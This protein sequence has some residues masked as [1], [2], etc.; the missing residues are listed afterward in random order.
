METDKVHPLKAYRVKHG[1]TLLQ[2]ADLV[3]VSEVS[4]SRYEAGRVPRPEIQRKIAE[5]THNAVQP[6]HLIAAGTPEP[7]AARPARPKRRATAGR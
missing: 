1:L 5:V 3:G 7:A 2:L 6:N 4:M